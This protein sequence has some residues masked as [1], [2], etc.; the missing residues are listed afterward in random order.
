MA[1]NGYEAAT[2][3]DFALRAHRGQNSISNLACSTQHVHCQRSFPLSTPVIIDQITANHERPT[4]G[5]AGY[6]LY[7]VL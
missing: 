3:I 6:Q 2:V 5:A 4:Q 1:G 7:R